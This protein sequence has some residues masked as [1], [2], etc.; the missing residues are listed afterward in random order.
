MEVEIRA[1][2]QDVE[3]LKSNLEKLEGVEEK[4]SPQRQVDIYLKHEKDEERKTVLRIRKDYESEEALLTFKAKNP[5]GYSDTAWQDFDT[6]IKEPDKL[7][8]LLTKNG[9]VYVCLIDKV[10]QSF[11]FKDMEIN[12]DNIRDLG[13]FVEIEKNIEEESGIEQAQ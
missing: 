1:Q 2:I 3:L 10:R 7:E 8:K 6:P 12:I 11:S 5:V 9:Y 4:S 13:V